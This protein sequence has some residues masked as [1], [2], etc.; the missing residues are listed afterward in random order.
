MKENKYFKIDE[1]KC[2]CGKCELPPNVPSDELIDT[3]CEIREHYNAPIII[4]SAY[5]CKEHN[6]KV[7]GAKNSQHSIGSAVDFTVKGIKTS[8]LHQH[9][10][11]TYGEKPFGI[12]IKHNLNNEFGG[13][14]HLD[15]RGKKARWTYA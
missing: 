15:T 9:I 4:N 8:D 3:L 2:K 6:E 12:A 13:F 1:F 5:R 14:V 11:N 7:G 10:L